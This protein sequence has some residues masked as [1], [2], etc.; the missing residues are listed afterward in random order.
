MQKAASL[1]AIRKVCCC[2]I[3]DEDDENDNS[4]NY[5]ICSDVASSCKASAT[6]NTLAP[7]AS[8]RSST[9]SSLKHPAFKPVSHSS[10]ERA[11][12]MLIHV[13]LTLVAKR[14]AKGPI[15]LT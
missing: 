15:Y 2:S 7:A 14:T 1:L 11:F 3:I 9:H 4:L 12:L 5:E 13:A 10:V 6:P 8:S